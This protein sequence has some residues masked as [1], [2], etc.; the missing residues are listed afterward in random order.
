MKTEVDLIYFEKDRE[1]QTRLSKYYVSH[2]NSETILDQTLI[3]SKDE[4][5][6]YIAKMAFTNFPKLK[7]EKET[8]LKLADRMKHMSEVIEEHWQDKIPHPEAA[9]SN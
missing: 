4:F 6:K 5:G 2:N 1:T 3:I 7:S 8:A 9:P